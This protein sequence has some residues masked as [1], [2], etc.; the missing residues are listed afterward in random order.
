MI[1]PVSPKSKIAACRS[2][3]CLGRL[4]VVAGCLLLAARAFDANAAEPAYTLLAYNSVSAIFNPL[5][6][7]R[8]APAEPTPAASVNEAS[9]FSTE[10]SL[11]SAETVLDQ[12]SAADPD[13]RYVAELTRSGREGLFGPGSLMLLQTRLPT[14]FSYRSWAGLHSGYGQIFSS[15]DT[16]GRSRV[17]GAGVDDPACLYL[18][19]SFNF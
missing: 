3:L 19:V 7:D 10:L 8:R 2:W 11:S 4:G 6:M 9:R 1:H 18:K 17:N 13:E 12:A 15:P 5:T 14:R 16:I